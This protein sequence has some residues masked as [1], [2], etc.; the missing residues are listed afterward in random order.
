MSGLWI[1]L[2]FFGGFNYFVEM[3]DVLNLLEIVYVNG[4]VMGLI[5]FGLEFGVLFFLFW[6][7]CDELLV[8]IDCIQIIKVWIIEDGVEEW[9]VDI[10]CSDGWVVDFIMGWCVV[11]LVMVDLS[12]CFIFGEVGVFELKVLWIDFDYDLNQNVFYY[13]CVIENLI[14]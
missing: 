14:C 5:F 7:V 12:D 13:V 6:V 2:W 3:F 11:M 4:V 8:L 9:V 10:I 1:R